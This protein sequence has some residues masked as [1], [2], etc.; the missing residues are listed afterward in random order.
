MQG[1]GLGEGIDWIPKMWV[2]GWPAVTVSEHLDPRVCHPPSWFPKPKPLESFL[3]TAFLSLH[4]WHPNHRQVLVTGSKL[5]SLNQ[6]RAFS[7]DF[8]YILVQATM[9]SCPDLFRSL[10]T[11]SPPSTR[12]T[13]YMRTLHPKLPLWPASHRGLHGQ[14]LRPVPFSPTVLRSHW[15]CLYF[16]NMPRSFPSLTSILT[17]LECSSFWSLFVLLLPVILKCQF[18]HYLFGEAVSDI[19]S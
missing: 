2:H 3:I 14:L 4:S 10:L 8:Y 16:W 13:I 12:T 5:Y 19:V 9:A 11:R 7:H 17:C 18:K 1:E 15:S 6:S